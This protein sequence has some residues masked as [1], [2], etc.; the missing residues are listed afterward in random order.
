MTR[1]RT[2]LVIGGGVAGPVTAMALAKAGIT[3]TVYEAHATPAEGLGVT[4]TLAPNGIAA[5]DIIGAGDAVRAIG[6]PMNRTV[7]TDGSGAL[8]GEMP[9]L[10]D[11]PPALG[12]WRD[13]LSRTLIDAARAQGVT[14]HFG[15]RL[16]RVTED[17]T[18]VTAQFA[19]GTTARGDILVG[20]DGMR[21]SVRR[22]IDPDAP[23]P[24]PVPLLNF[25]AAADGLVPGAAPDAMYFVFGARA[26]FGY[27]V[28]PDGRTAWF[29]NV[30]EARVMTHADANRCSPEVWMQRLRDEFA[31]DTPARDV[32]ART[33]AADLRA[34]GSI[35]SMPPVPHWHRGR[36]VLVGDAVHGPS[37]SS[38]QGASIAIESAIELARCLR[39]LPEPESAF[40]AYTHLRRARVQ[41]IIR[42][43]DRTTNSKSVGRIAKT[44]MRLIMPLAVRTFLNPEKTLGP[45]HRY[46]IDW[47]KPVVATPAA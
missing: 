43:G 19:D 24:K 9:H 14:V 15:K 18:G 36:M 27:W 1:V 8:I 28:Q 2:A 31:A 35:E 11:Q 45:E 40:A 42:R 23:A 7:V 38:G 29:A 4:L 3:A 20:A 41:G 34:I 32:I 17:D 12:L 5:L 22:L 46:R 33:R 30:P 44:L 25:G 39:D 37:P 10:S 26:F 21:S 47:T 13:D 16:V 6:L